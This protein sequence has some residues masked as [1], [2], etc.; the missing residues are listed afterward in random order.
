[1]SEENTGVMRLN[2]MSH[3]RAQHVEP[4]QRT[5]KKQSMICYHYEKYGHTRHYYFEWIKLNI[6]GRKEGSA[7]KKWKSNVASTSVEVHT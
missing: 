4:R 7:K 1:M 2:Q 5:N 6:R 3:H